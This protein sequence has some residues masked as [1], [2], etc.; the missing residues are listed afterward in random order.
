MTTKQAFRRHG[1]SL[2]EVIACI[3]LVSMMI[4]P[5]AGVIRASGQSIA[6]AEASGSTQAQLR[7]ALT[8]I[9]NTFRHSQYL[10]T[11]GQAVKLLTSGRVVK[12]GVDSGQFVIDDGKSQ[13]VIA[14][15][16][17]DSRFE[18]LTQTTAP[19]QRVG[20]RMTLR[21]R[22]RDTGA[23]VSVTATSADAPQM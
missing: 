12:I 5:L 10:G 16:V 19:F 13:T 11:D 14:G 21:S 7:V 8:W 15:D 18:E 2:I 3:V 23:I 20:L 22:D 9:Q 1:I 17:L 4:V 6:Q